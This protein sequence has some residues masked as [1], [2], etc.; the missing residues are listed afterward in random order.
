MAH[1]LFIRQGKAIHNNIRAEIVDRWLND[2][3]QRQKG[4]D[5]NT[6]KSTVQNIIDNF[7]K[8]GQQYSRIWREQNANGRMMS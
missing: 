1:N 5:L 2:T 3:G 6:E 4:R 8:H 7:L